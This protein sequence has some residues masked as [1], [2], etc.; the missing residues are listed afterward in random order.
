M[1][2][3]DYEINKELG[4]CYLFMGEYGKARDYYNKAVLDNAMMADPYMG[5]AAIAV[6]EGD[7]EGAHVLYSK[8]NAVSPGEKPLTGLGMI[9][10][11]LGRYAEA[12][13]HFSAALKLN[14]GN[15]LVVNGILQLAY[16]LNRLEEV[17]PYLEAALEPGD[18]EAV[19]YALAACLVSIGRDEEA[20]KHLEIL[21]GEHPANDSAKQLYAQFAA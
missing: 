21:L 5:L 4:E 18:T 19:R 17:L 10:V 16:V 1:N 9:E 8:A 15:M 6:Q 3:I 2:H 14:P 7:L 20:K 11:E 12:F 13:E